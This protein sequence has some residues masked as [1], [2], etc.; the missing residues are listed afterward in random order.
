MKE[1]RS[2][3]NAVFLSEPRHLLPLVPALFATGAAG[4]VLLARRGWPTYR[5]QG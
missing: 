2:A 5:K 4:W 1:L 3:V